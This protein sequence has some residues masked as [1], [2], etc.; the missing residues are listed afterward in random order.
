MRGEQDERNQGGGGQRHRLGHPPHAP[1]DGRG[2]GQPPAG[3][4]HAGGLLGVGGADDSADGV[5]GGAR[6][7]P[8]PPGPPPP[9]PRGGG[10]ANP[11]RPGAAPGGGRGGAG[12]APPRGGG[13][14]RPRRPPPPPRNRPHVQRRG[15]DSNPRYARRTAVFKT[16]TFGRSV[17]SPCPDG[18]ALR[19]YHHRVP[20]DARTELRHPREKS[21]RRRPCRTGAATGATGSSRRPSARACAIVGHTGRREARVACRA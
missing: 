3:F 18:R 17:T 16:A 9:P 21:P 7:G 11:R 5:G 19:H 2:G 15:R 6:G 4:G 12:R 14:G 8:P 10:G 20:G 1:E 13:G